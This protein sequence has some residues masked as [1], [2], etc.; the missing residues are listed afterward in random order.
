M[1]FA[2]SCGLTVYGDSGKFWIPFHFVGKARAHASKSVASATC[3]EPSP[4]WGGWG[5]GTWTIKNSVPECTVTEGPGH[6]SETEGSSRMERVASGRRPL[7]KMD[8]ERTLAW[9][10][11]GPEEKVEG[12]RVKFSVCAS[13]FSSQRKH[14]ESLEGLAL[15][16]PVNVTGWQSKNPNVS[17]PRAGP[18]DVDSA[19]SVCLHTLGAMSSSN[20][21]ARLLF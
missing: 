14:T 19:R 16:S 5:P 3:P 11:E 20:I 13:D 17:E 7:P 4:Y 6:T 21:F 2:Y 15:A 9:H 10:R 12:I 18:S 8:G 1:G